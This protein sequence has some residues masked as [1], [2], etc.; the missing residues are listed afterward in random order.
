MRWFS[1]QDALAERTL[2]PLIGFAMKDFLTK[3]W[4][5]EV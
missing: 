4:V 3:G 1:F 5:E 2:N